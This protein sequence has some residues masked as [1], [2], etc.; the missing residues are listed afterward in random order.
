M[1]D[2]VVSCLIDILMLGSGRTTPKVLNKTMLSPSYLPQ[3]C[4]TKL[5][6]GC[7]HHGRL[8]RTLCSNLFPLYQ[9]MEDSDRARKAGAAAAAVCR[10]ADNAK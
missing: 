9:W 8:A 4:Y 6:N 2:P 10:T 7:P 3:T 5:G 1:A